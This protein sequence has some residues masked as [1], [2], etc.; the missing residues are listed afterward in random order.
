MVEKK[1]EK[2]RVWIGTVWPILVL[3]GGIVYHYET[4]L[5][6]CQTTIQVIENDVKWIKDGVSRTEALNQQIL[7]RLTE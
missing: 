5:N 2:I 4:R 7:E 6:E 1:D 3:I